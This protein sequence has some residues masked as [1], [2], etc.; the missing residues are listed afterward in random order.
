MSNLAL[1]ICL[2]HFGLFVLVALERE[3]KKNGFCIERVLKEF[4]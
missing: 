3:A 4:P 1:I 2:C